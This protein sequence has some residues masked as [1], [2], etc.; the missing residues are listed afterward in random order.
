MG[1]SPLIFRMKELTAHFTKTSQ[2]ASFPTGLSL[3][4]PSAQSWRLAIV[5]ALFV[6]GS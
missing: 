4:G 5:L 6:L 3:L 2:Y 1:L